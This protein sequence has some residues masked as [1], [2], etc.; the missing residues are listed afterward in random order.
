MGVACHKTVGKRAPFPLAFSQLLVLLVAVFPAVTL[1]TAVLFTQPN[2]IAVCF[3]PQG[4][5]PNAA[6]RELGNVENLP[7]MHRVCS[8]TRPTVNVIQ[9]WASNRELTADLDRRH[10][11][12]PRN[13]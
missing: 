5:C 8:R 4:G 1:V 6:V 2:P 13:S 11:M 9:H 12:V 3:S 10:S 7:V